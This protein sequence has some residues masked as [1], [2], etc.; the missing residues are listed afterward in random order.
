MR[1]DFFSL[2]FVKKQS[3]N[4]ITMEKIELLRQRFGSYGAVAQIMSISRR[5]L[6][7]YRKGRIPPRLRPLIEMQLDDILAGNGSPLTSQAEPA[8]QTA[9]K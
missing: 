8:A 1:C 9:D 7:N 4:S 6:I 3:H 2:A 5:T